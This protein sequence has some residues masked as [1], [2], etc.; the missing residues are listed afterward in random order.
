MGSRLLDVPQGSSALVRGLGLLT[1]Q[2]LNGFVEEGWTLSLALAPLSLCFYF[3]SSLLHSNYTS[4]PSLPLLFL[5]PSLSLRFLF[6]YFLIVLFVGQSNFPP[7]GVFFMDHV[8]EFASVMTS[9]L[10]LKREFSP[11]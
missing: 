10:Q 2:E 11:N 3:F 5:A 9:D 1:V 4:L 6:I 7:E 8:V